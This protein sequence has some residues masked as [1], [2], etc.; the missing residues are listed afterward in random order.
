MFKISKDSLLKLNEAMQKTIMDMNYDNPLEISAFA[1]TM[2]S[3]GNQIN[4]EV[5]KDI[6]KNNGRN[7][8]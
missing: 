5:I 3:V 7:P 1:S 8:K 4:L 6:T 2:I